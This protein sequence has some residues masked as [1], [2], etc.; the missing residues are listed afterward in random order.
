[1][2]AKNNKDTTKA[3]N[4]SNRKQ[5]HNKTNKH[6]GPPTKYLGHVKFNLDT[7]KYESDE[8]TPTLDAHVSRVGKYWSTGWSNTV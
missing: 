7:G 4:K 8:L 3:T 2:N 1:M 5:T 6:S